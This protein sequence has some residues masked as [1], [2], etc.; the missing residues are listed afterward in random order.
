MLLQQVFQVVGEH[1]EE[2][3]QCWRPTDQLGQLREEAE[4]LHAA[5]QRRAMALMRTSRHLENLRHRLARSSAPNIE[6][7]RAALEQGEQRYQVRLK[8]IRRI[9]RRLAR[10]RDEIRIRAALLAINRRHG[11][12]NAAE[13]IPRPLGEK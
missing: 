10:V 9:R 12:I 8:R 4:R 1:F 3:T 2:L 7:C 13:P 6:A 11:V 5:L